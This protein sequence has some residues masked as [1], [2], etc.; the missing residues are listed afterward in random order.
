MTSK[1]GMTAC[2]RKLPF[3]PS[4]ARMFASASCLRSQAFAGLTRA[5]AA[6]WATIKAETLRHP[7]GTSAGFAPCI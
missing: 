7:T 6:E 5:I 2:V 1:D 3:G 4:A